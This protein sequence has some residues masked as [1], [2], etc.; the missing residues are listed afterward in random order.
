MK[1]PLPHI[2]DLDFPSYYTLDLC[3]WWMVGVGVVV[4]CPDLARLGWAARKACC[5]KIP[6]FLSP[7][8]F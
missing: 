6:Y 4:M 3:V 5:L 2:R 8:K 1:F 7:I